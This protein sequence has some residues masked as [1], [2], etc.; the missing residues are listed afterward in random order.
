[1]I[2]GAAFRRSA[3]TLLLLWLC[4]WT[5]SDH[6]GV[7]LPELNSRFFLLVVLALLLVP[8]KNRD[9]MKTWEYK[10]GTWESNGVT[11]VLLT[12]EVRTDFV[13]L[14]AVV[15]AVLPAAQRQGLQSKAT[16]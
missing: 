5:P 9:K 8:T 15:E 13:E 4:A 2:L 3:E 7:C 14:F 16:A 1:M 12:L 11:Y 6:K 10:R